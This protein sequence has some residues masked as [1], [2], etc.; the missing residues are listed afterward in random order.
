MTTRSGTQYHPQDPTS[1]MDLALAHITKLLEDLTTRL[2]NVEQEL[3]NTREREA[4][5]NVS[6]N[7][8]R[9][10]PRHCRNNDQTIL[11]ERT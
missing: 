7:G 9:S 2:T 11:R 10:G 1:E 4:T 6:D 3:R 5:D 8:P